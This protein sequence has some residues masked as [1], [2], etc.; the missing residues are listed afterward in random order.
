MSRLRPLARAWTAAA[1]I[2]LNTLAL[3]V[4][5]NLI[6][7][8]ALAL[9]GAAGHRVSPAYDGLM[10]YGHEVLRQVYPGR[11]DADIE[12]LLRETWTLPLV[13]EPYTQ[14]RESAVSGRWVNVDPAGFRRDAAGGPPWP[15]PGSDRTVFLFGGSTIFGYGL[16]DGETLAERLASR[17]A[18][19]VPSDGAV[20]VYNFGRAYYNSTQERVLFERLLAAG[21]RPWAAVFVDGLNDTLL[22]PR[23]RDEPQHTEAFRDFVARRR[24]NVGWGTD[25]PDPSGLWRALQRLPLVRAAQGLLRRA[26]RD[27]RRE[28]L[29]AGDPGA[30]ELAREARELAAVHAANRRLAAAAA[31]AH[32]VETLWVLQP[33]PWVRYD[34]SRHHFRPPPET[35]AGLERR[36]AAAYGALRG[37]AAGA[38]ADCSGALEG[39]AEPAY[40]DTHHYTA[41]AVEE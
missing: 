39:L 36:F 21:H 7:W 29:E 14:F 40:L 11:S 25:D 38:P 22:W 3:L 41:A 10:S 37:A 26:G 17:L 12:A 2:L 33:V 19:A 6:A 9:A 27:A 24:F 18:D 31:A 13:Y 34:L 8:L 23:H 20:R 35:S 1:L 4:A 32:G 5:L 15:P 30:G 16:A 28:A